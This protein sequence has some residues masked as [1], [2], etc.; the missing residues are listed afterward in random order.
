MDL[1]QMV[2][3]EA[4]DMTF[5]LRNDYDESGRLVA[6]ECVGWYHGSPDYKATREFTGKL[7]AEY[8]PIDMEVKPWS[9]CT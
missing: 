2:Y 9:E 4:D 3:C 7:R 5:I 1:M 6:T 8:D